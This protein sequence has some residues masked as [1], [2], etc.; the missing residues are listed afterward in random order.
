MKK[1]FKFLLWAIGIFLA[2]IVC[3]AVWNAYQAKQT[4][5]VLKNIMEAGQSEAEIHQQALKSAGAH[6]KVNHPTD[7]MTDKAF[8]VAS[9]TSINEVDFDFPYD[10]GSLLTMYVREKDNNTDVFFRI[11]KGQFVCNEYS[12]T[13]V[14]TIRFD[15]EAPQ[16]F[17][18]S[19]SS[20]ND[21]SILFV[22]R[23]SDAKK[24]IQKCKTAKTMKVQLNFYSEGARIF[25]F[26]VEE[27]LSF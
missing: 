26:E 11:S 19:E 7:E 4:E 5:D 12:G 6:W 18:A 17:K 9:V 14:I 23:S 20:T 27:P 21:S 25:N 3:V 2:F 13:D 8:V 24:I 15:D 16:K 1:F 22:A 10:G